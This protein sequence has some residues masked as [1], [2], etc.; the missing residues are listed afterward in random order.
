V[1]VLAVY[2]AVLSVMP[3]GA[4]WSPDEGAKFIQLHSIG[5]QGGLRYAIPYGGLRLDP[6]Y[7]FYPTRCR[8]E[9]L[10][11]VPLA[12][13]GVKFHWP[14]WFPLLSAPLASAFGLSGLYVVP[15]LSGW[16][17]ALLAGHLMR[18]WDERLAPLAILAVGLATPV[19]F[20]SL[21]FWEHTLTA[22]L[23]LAALAIVAAG[24]TLRRAAVWLV[25]PLLLAAAAL[26]IEMLLFG[27]AVVCAWFAAGRLATDDAVAVAASGDAT[28]RP[29]R[30]L[31]FAFGVAVVAVAVALLFTEAIPERHRW[32]LASLPSYLAG[33]IA[34]L[35]YL[36]ETLTA[37]LV[38]SPGNQAPVI[39]HLWRYGILTA[40]W[41]VALA[42]LLRSWRREAIVLLPAL[43]VIL[44]F[45]TYLIVRPQAY[46]SLH[47]FLPVAP[48]IVLALY[49]VAPV[50][51]QRRH[52]QVVLVVAAAAYAVL[53]FTAVLV[54]VVHPD[55]VMPTGL[56]WGN[57]YLF[58]LY[59]VGTILALGALHEYRRSTRPALL[60][61]AVTLAAA[62]L[63]ACGL[64]LQV[65]GVWT[66]V[67]TRRLVTAWQSALRDEPPVM[68]NV[69]WLPAAMAPL[70]ISHEM[71]CVRR[72][73]DLGAWLPVALEHGVDTFTFAS[74]RA[75][76]T[77]RI[78]HDGFAVEREGERV[79]SG[80][81]LT[82][83][84]IAPAPAAVAP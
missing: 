1:F 49:A 64:L 82:R 71:H 68:T 47:G 37:V 13:G 23:G 51:R 4:F 9:D 15:L 10:Y 75:L 84:R 48:V 33:A 76:D 78:P 41:G 83:V 74:F 58:A 36:A 29:V 73:R 11:P 16:L 6:E 69:W 2:A 44:E 18:A 34:K 52:A 7:A 31:L 21:T 38:D 79:V 77:D 27:A 32:I 3:K 43:A 45:S 24:R 14:I 30:R 35:P 22:L 12:D 40:C 80:L 59:P 63:L 57:R 70:F 50:W 66:L 26:R 39:P 46:V 28:A 72:V 53:A 20:F 67:E 55:G 54:F 17:V 60:K 42:S 81:H 65:R 62:G 5:W 56:E 25:V 19:A 8:F 61:R